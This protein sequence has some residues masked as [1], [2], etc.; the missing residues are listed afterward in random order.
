MNDAILTTINLPQRTVVTQCKHHGC[1]EGPSD[2]SALVA[3]SKFVASFPKFHPLTACTAR[4]CKGV[5]LQGNKHEHLCLTAL[6]LPWV[7]YVAVWGQLLSISTRQRGTNVTAS[8]H[9]R[10]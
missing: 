4:G 9:C 7:H 8:K 1:V 10:P 2:V 3:W 6:R 5:V